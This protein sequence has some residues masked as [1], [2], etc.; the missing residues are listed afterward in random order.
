MNAKTKPTADLPSDIAALAAITQTVLAYRKEKPTLGGVA[1]IAVPNA[2]TATLP[3]G[4]YFDALQVS[5]GDSS[6]HSG[7]GQILVAANPFGSDGTAGRMRGLRR[8]AQ[9]ASN[10]PRCDHD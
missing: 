5:F 9:R 7:I 8:T 2:K 4:V 3:A 1:R 6:R 10:R